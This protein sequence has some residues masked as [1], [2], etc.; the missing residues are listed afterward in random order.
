LP[1]RDRN[2]GAGGSARTVTLALLL[3]GGAGASA[4]SSL[5]LEFIGEHIIQTGARFEGTTIGGLSGIDFDPDSGVYYAISDARGAGARFYALDIDLEPTRIASVRFGRVTALR[6]V[7]G[8]NFAR[9]PGSGPRPDPESIRFDPGSGTLYWSSEG[10]GTASLDPWIREAGRDGAFRREITTPV[11]FRRT[12]PGTG[13]R[14]NQG[15]E[16]LAINGDG[17]TLF[18]ANENALLQDGPA[19]NRVDGS[20]V[21]IVALDK[22]TASVDA[23]YAYY[24]E[25]VPRVPRGH[26]GTRANGLVELLALGPDRLLALERAYVAGSGNFV[27]LFEVDLAGASDVSNVVSLNAD[28]DWR[29]VKKHRIADLHS[30]RSEILDARAGSAF[31]HETKVVDNLEG[32]TFGPTVGGERTIVFVSDNNFGIFGPQFTQ[33]LAFRIRAH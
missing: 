15:F 32:M 23:E 27:T 5:S 1:R 22:H 19:A 7:G 18:V 26:S 9:L 4:T 12:T 6:D 21:R 24:V 11:K 13:V 20:F 28:G 8:R 10:D 29:P 25:P 16:S 30:F 17:A 33:F 31:A 3:C 14:D 2:G